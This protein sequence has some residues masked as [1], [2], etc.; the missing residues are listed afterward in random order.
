[1]VC[2]SSRR[3]SDQVFVQNPSF[4][5]TGSAPAAPGYLDSRA[6]AGWTYESQGGRFGLNDSAGPFHD[7]GVVPDGH[8]VAFLQKSGSLQQRIMGLEPGERYELQY[9]V[10]ARA[11]TQPA[12]LRVLVDGELLHAETIQAVGGTQTYRL[13]THRFTATSPSALLTFQQSLPNSNVD[14]S[15]LIDQVAV[16][17]LKSPLVTSL[18]LGPTT[19]YFR[20]TFDYA[21]KPQQTELALRT[22]LDDGA[23]MYLNGVE[24]LRQNVPSGPVISSTLATTEVGDPAWGPWQTISADSLVTG[25]NVLAVEVHQAAMNDR[26]MALAHRTEGDRNAR[27]PDAAQIAAGHQRTRRSR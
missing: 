12:E 2:R 23:V 15:L 22:F 9:Y 10:N 17:L 3:A 13:R 16:R 20:Q 8:L 24:V 6:L 14:A 7:N 25:R 1:M 5:A 11:S 21:G 4:E 26:D 19:Y 18:P 27:R